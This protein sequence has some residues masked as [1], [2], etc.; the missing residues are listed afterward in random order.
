MNA[1]GKALTDFENFKVNLIDWIYQDKNSELITDDLDTLSEHQAMYA[2]LLDNGWMDIFGVSILRTEKWM[3]VTLHSSTVTFSMRL[4][5]CLKAWQNCKKIE[6]GNFMAMNRTTQ[7]LLIPHSNY[8]LNYYS[9][10]IN[11]SH[12]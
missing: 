1:R 6:F 11:C 5:L 8:I 2:S 4:S 10:P 12:D 7:G 3:K 9:P